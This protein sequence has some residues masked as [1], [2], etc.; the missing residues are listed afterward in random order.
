MVK[1]ALALMVL[2]NCL[3]CGESLLMSAAL[4]LFFPG[5]SLHCPQS[6]GIQVRNLSNAPGYYITV[7]CV[8]FLAA[9]GGKNT[10]IEIGDMEINQYR[11]FYYSR[12]SAFRWERFFARMK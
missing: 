12:R 4:M 11:P 8:A 5:T 2:V 10:H 1:M 6:K 9:V 3:E 7:R